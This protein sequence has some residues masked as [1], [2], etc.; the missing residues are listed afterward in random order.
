MRET[1][2]SLGQSLHHSVLAWIALT[3]RRQ[4]RRVRMWDARI[5]VTHVECA[6]ESQDGG[7]SARCLRPR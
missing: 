1:R 5:D 7:N 6:H 4:L 2:R 3:E